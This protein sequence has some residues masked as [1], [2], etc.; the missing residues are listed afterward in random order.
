MAQGYPA[1]PSAP[2]PTIP[3]GRSGCPTLPFMI[4][5]S[6]HYLDG[7]RDDEGLSLAEAGRRAAQGRGFV[8]L[9]L[10]D[11]SAEELAQL[12][13]SFDVPALAVED[14][15]EGHQ[16]PKL[17]RYGDGEF[18]VVK[19]VHHRGGERRLIF[20]ELEAFFGPS[21]A[22]V[23]GWH[24]PAALAGARERLDAHPELVRLGPRA[25]AWAVLDTVVD[26]YEPVLDVLADALEETEQAV[27]QQRLDQ[28]ERIYLQ[29]REAGRLARVVHPLGGVFDGVAHGDPSELPEQLR[30]LLRDVGDHV[31]RLSE[32]IALLGESLDAL[33]NANLAAVT[34]RQN[35]VVQ[36][37]SGWAA[38]AAVPTVITGV[39]GMNFR[40]MPELG[41][42]I[43]YPLVVIVMI[44]VVVGL[45]RYF[46]HV[47]W[48]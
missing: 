24:S 36:K 39:Y 46:R 27:F 12:G 3:T 1:H 13:T 47:G 22:I 43:G 37:V 29:R 38:L 32:E 41:W 20:G 30:P 23:A 28:G 33:L 18:L 9:A 11:P 42:S 7:T 14:M 31:H 45:R 34:V 8:W 16:R 19:T 21:C 6:A 25:A 48:F 35:Q 4:I 40:H 17:E 10:S 44:A 15:R 2:P 26:A 5:D